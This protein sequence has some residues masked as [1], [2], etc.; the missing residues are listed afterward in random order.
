MSLIL[1]INFQ[2]L[3]P[4]KNTN[5]NN[6]L[7]R[8]F[9]RGMDVHAWGLSESSSQDNFGIIPETSVNGAS[10]WKYV[11]RSL[12]SPEK[13]VGEDFSGV[14][15]AAGTNSGFDVGDEVYGI[16]FTVAG[17]TLQDIISVSTKSSIV[18]RKPEDMSWEQAAAL[19]LVWLTARTT[20]ARVESCLQKS[21]RLTVLG[22]SS[23]VGMHVLQLANQ[24][25]WKVLTTC[26]S[27]NSEFVKSMGA[28]SV[29]DYKTDDVVQAVRDF[30]PAAIID[31]VGGTLCIGLAERYVTIVG[32]KTGRDSMGGAAI[33]F[34]HPKMAI[35]TILGKIGLG[36]GYDCVNLEFR[37]EWLEETLNLDRSNIVIDST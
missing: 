29:V 11:P 27:R 13:G 25:G 15:E 4:A 30:G 16:T 31:C 20:I 5:N 23:A 22:G 3:G 1:K 32:D 37:K 21:G 33:Y 12:I 18:V 26:S 8:Q 36:K 14:V 2:L 9:Y 35:R 7:G 24:R 6:G 10:L 17:G 34:W 28:T 19:P